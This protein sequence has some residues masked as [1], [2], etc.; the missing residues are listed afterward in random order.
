[1]SFGHKVSVRELRWDEVVLGEVD[2]PKERL[3]IT[4]GFGSGLATCSGV[5]NGDVWAICDRGPN[6]KL[7]DAVERYGWSPQRGVELGAGAKLMPRTDIGPALALLHV[8]ETDVWL[9][10]TLSI[11]TPAGRSVSGRPIPQSRE[12]RCEPAF[13]L[14][15]TE[16]Q[17]DPT[18][19]DTEGLAVLADGSFWASEEY[20]PSLV[21]LTPNGEVVERLVPKGIELPGAGYP[22]KSCL[23]ALAAKRYLNRGFEAVSTSPSDE[24][25]FVAFQS[26]LAHPDEDAHKNARH[27]RIWTLD[28]SRS[29]TGQFL[30]RLDDPASFRR[31]NEQSKVKLRDLK[32]CEMVATSEDALLVLERATET[33]KIYRTR[34]QDGCALP[35]EHLDA[36]TR[37]TIEELSAATAELP[38]LEKELLFTSDEWPEVSADVEGMAL[39]DRRSLLIVTDNDFGCEGKQTRFYRL[40]FDF[41][42]VD[43]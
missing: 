26:P 32:V 29:V 3:I 33:S 18:G 13:S 12:G 19:M 4:A 10:E 16:L 6:L 25:L 15:G 42:L 17:P 36:E 39:L 40:T 31:D 41:S 2:F 38:E 14:D 8:T 7:D 37:P 22:V 11:K 24:R 20:G 5:T 28:R 35:D 21:R 27:V 34:L 43:P 23:P 1:M 9:V 30:Y